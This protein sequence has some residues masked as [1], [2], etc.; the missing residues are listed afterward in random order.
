MTTTETATEVQ[1]TATDKP[2]VHLLPLSLGRLAEHA[3]QKDSGRRFVLTGIRLRFN[4]DGS[5]IAEATDT[6]QAARIT[7][8][9]EQSPDAPYPE[10]PALVSA[11]N[12]ATDVLIP[13]AAWRKAFATATKL[14]KPRA[15]SSKP[16]LRHV[17][18]VT[19]SE[20]T[21][22]GATDTETVQVD[23]VR[24][25][26]GRFPTTDDVFNQAADRYPIATVRINPAYLIEILKTAMALT[27]DDDKAVELEIHGPGQPV[28]VKAK[29][30]RTSME[31]T[32]LVQPL[33]G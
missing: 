29:G 19:G 17:A 13:G 32:G 22:F 7:G 27:T 28:V 14:T 33:C 24:N 9:V 10:L 31:F 20:V 21:T 3:E 16:I 26:E 30:Y 25:L 11:P 6:K 23:T 4:P 12:G 2:T 5:F 18:A 8:T 1:T 15:V